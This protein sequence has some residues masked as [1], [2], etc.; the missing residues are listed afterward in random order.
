MIKIADIHGRKNGQKIVCLT[1]YNA[2]YADILDK[3]A[4]IL[5]V[6]DSLGM[7]LYSLPSTNAVPLDVMIWH[8]KSVTSKPRNALVVA[9][10]PF[11][12]YQRDKKHAFTNAARMM[13]EGGVG[14][15]MGHVGLLPQSAALTGY[16]AQG[17]SDEDKARIV[18]DAKALEQAGAFAI[19]CE[20]VTKETAEAVVDAVNVPIIGIGASEKCSGQVLVTE[21]MLGITC[22]NMP[23]FVKKYKDLRAEIEKAVSAF[24]ADIRNGTFP[25]SINLY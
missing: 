11:G 4:D 24:S 7:V 9:D 6:G 25:S 14:A 21:D 22:G 12:S 18:A 19:V 15:V 3:Y 5:L 16:K 2:L 1:A 17:R 8:A 10:L 20:A 23:K 13:A